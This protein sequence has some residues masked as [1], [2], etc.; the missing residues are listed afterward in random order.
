MNS[1]SKWL[2]IDY[3][4]RSLSF[5]WNTEI[6]VA[7]QSLYA[8]LRSLGLDLNQARFSNYKQQHEFKSWTDCIS[9]ITNT[10]GKGTNPIIL[11]PAMGK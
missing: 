1:M 2:S 6:M 10:L 11:P 9:H 8:N 7:A 5:E 3:S 4:E